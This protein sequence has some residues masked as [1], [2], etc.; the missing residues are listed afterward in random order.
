[1]ALQE[2]AHHIEVA[3]ET[4]DLAKAG[5]FAAQLDKQFEVLK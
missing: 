3:G 5:S 2:M 1:V 4:G